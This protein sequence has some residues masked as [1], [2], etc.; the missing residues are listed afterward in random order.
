MKENSGR[1][2]GL[3]TTQMSQYFTMSARN[4]ITDDKLNSLFVSN[5]FQTILLKTFCFKI[6]I[7]RYYFKGRAQTNH[8]IMRSCYYQN[9]S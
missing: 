1:K 8:Y 9:Q 4:Y 7:T 6:Q 5:M 2:D 3:V